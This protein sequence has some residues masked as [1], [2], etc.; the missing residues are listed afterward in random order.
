MSYYNGV[1]VLFSNLLRT[2]TGIKATMA[3]AIKHS[4]FIGVKSS[5]LS[6]DDNRS[7]AAPACTCMNDG[8]ATPTSVPQKKAPN[9]TPK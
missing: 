8:G 3:T 7:R 9:G 6:E 4:T 2:N 1:L 5:S